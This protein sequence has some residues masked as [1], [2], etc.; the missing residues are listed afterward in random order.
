[1]SSLLTELSR[2]ALTLSAEEREQLAE[3]LLV[4]LRGETSPDIESAW[5][6]ELCRR[7]SSIASGTAVLIPA[8]DVFAEARR[9]LKR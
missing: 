9:L 4:S 1:M 5:D 2:Q 8:A 7:V 6:E 3:E